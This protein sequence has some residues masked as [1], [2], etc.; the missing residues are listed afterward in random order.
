MLFEGHGSKGAT[1]QAY[2]RECSQGRT[3][4]NAS[5]SLVSGVQVF[6]G[7]ARCGAP[8]A[9]SARHQSVR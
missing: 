5:N 9:C 4:L 1:L 3:T 2:Y 8:P 6:V 7:G